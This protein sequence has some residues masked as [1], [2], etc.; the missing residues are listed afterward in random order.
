[1]NVGVK[2]KKNTDSEH[3]LKQQIFIPSCQKA[4]LRAY[5]QLNNYK[6]KLFLSMG[7][8]EIKAHL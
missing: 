1:L 6:I 7:I 4:E 8:R 5:D 3:L 2:Y